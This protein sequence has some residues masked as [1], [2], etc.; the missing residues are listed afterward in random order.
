MLKNYIKQ[1]VYNT[2]KLNEKSSNT[3]YP[4]ITHIGNT[5]VNVHVAITYASNNLPH[6]SLNTILFLFLII[7]PATKQ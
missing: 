7:N 6:L 2:T 5:K 4:D 1:N 3:N